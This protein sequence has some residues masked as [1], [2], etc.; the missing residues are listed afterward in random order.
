MLTYILNYLLN[1]MY[2]SLALQSHEKKKT[3]V[4]SNVFLISVVHAGEWLLIEVSKMK[5]LQ[6]WTNP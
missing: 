6:K 3:E 4:I 2:R 5:S 1:Q